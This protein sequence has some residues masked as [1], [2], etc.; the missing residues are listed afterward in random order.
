MVDCKKT[1]QALF[2][3]WFAT[4]AAFTAKAAARSIA[5]ASRVGRTQ[6]TCD[7]QHEYKSVYNQLNWIISFV[8]S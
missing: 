7:S 6:T 8:D 2:C 4:G 3:Y 1:I 5:Q